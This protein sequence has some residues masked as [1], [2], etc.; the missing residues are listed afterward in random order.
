MTINYRTKN[1]YDLFR[2]WLKQAED[3]ELNDPGAMCL[4][5][6]D[7]NGHPDN[8]MVLL[9][10]LDER[11]FVFYTNEKSNKG[12]ALA[13]HPY[14]ALC[15]HWKSLQ[16]QVRVRGPIDMVSEEEAD[17]YYASRARGSRIGA[18][19]SKQSQPLKDYAEL[20]EFVEGE[21]KKFAGVED[22][23]R[24][25]YWRG[26]RIVPERIEFWIDGQYRLHERY[27]YK[28]D[29]NGEWQCGMLYP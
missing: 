11:G 12:Q 27:V 13:A 28:R 6:V 25:P 9:K 24:P 3:N 10:G 4:A 19:A 23:P 26:Y 17:A 20:K 14:A 7:K 22:I 21:E 8:R 2:D 29:E 18:W 5:T 1:P 15:F 16:K